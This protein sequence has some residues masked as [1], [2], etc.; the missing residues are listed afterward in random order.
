MAGPDLGFDQ[1]ETQPP[2]K[3]G[4]GNVFTVLEMVHSEAL[5]SKRMFKPLMGDL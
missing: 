1:R 2:I 4:P 5:Y 3:E